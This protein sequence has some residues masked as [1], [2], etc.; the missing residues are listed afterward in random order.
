MATVSRI[1][2]YI[3]PLVLLVLVGVIFLS[4]S[5]AWGDLKEAVLS[6]G[7]VLEVFLPKFSI[8]L[9]EQ[10][11]EVSIPDEHQQSIVKLTETISSM[12]GQGKENCF[13]N[14]GSFPD[15]GEGGTSL[16]F[17]S[18]GDYTAMTVRG[19]AGG[20]Q[21][22][23]GLYKEIPAMKPCVIAGTFEESKKFF[24]HFIAGG[25][26]EYPYYRAVNS[27]T[28]YYSTGG[29]GGISGNHIYV[30][31]FGEEP[32]NDEGDNL[33]DGGWLF[34]PD[35]EH[36]CFFPTDKLDLFSETS[37]DGIAGAIF[38]EKRYL[39]KEKNLRYRINAGELKLCS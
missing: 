5:G 32:V 25:K 10:K 39:N 3:I 1:I 2:S 37:D 38:L 30:A 36:I 14:Y 12:L 18:K 8:G 24:E 13:A 9:E 7:D 11:A 23:T 26:L 6:A 29:I 31:D 27:M 16:A 4:E 33:E 17:E 28:I 20:K 15:F 22:I 35:G 19:G 21:I 34:T